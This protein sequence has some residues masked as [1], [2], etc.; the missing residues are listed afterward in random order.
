MG[1]TIINWRYGREKV[2]RDYL[3]CEIVVFYLFLL[4]FVI[5]NFLYL[6]IL[7]YY[8]SWK[9]VYLLYILMEFLF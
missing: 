7:K 3:F 6:I 5:L 4:Y 1:M 9:M 8:D 2:L